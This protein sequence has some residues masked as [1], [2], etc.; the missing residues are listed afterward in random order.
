MGH[1]GPTLRCINV[2]PK[3][4]FSNRGTRISE[5]ILKFEKIYRFIF[6]ILASV[7]GFKI[8]IYFSYFD[9]KMPIVENIIIIQK[10]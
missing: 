9:L 2:S 4:T 10:T 7:L 1:S 3:S 6:Y 5:N 8:R